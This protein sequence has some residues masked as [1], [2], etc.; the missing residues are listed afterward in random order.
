MTINNLLPGTFDA[1]GLKANLTALARN[2]SRN[3]SEVTEEVGTSNPSKRF[4]RPDESGA[5]SDC[6]RASADGVVL[7][8][9]LGLAPNH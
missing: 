3:M 9:A 5:S 8:H 1:D 2:S 4:G 7:L 6:L